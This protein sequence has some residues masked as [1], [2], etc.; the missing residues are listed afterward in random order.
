MGRLIRLSD[1][2]SKCL[3]DL[4]ES[5]GL[6]TISATVSVIVKQA[7]DKLDAPAKRGGA[8]QQ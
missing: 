8:T 3:E 6:E 2:A 5:L 1:A 4:Q 7:H